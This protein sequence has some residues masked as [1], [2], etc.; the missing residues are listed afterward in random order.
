M[1]L[2]FDLHEPARICMGMHVSRVEISGALCGVLEWVWS[3]VVGLQSWGGRDL[4]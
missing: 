1:L 3:W 4:S 2:L